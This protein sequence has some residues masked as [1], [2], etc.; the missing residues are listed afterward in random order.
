MRNIDL[1]ERKRFDLPNLNC[2]FGHVNRNL[3]LNLSTFRS[4]ATEDGLLNALLC[5]AAVGF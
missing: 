2:Y 1:R 3:N 4:A 5:R